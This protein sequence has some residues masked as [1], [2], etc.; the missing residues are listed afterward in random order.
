MKIRKFFE[1][2]TIDD[3]NDFLIDFKDEGFEVDSEYFQGKVLISGKF[4]GELNRIEFLENILNLVSRIESEGYKS[5]NDK[6]HIYTG[7]VDGKPRCS[8]KLR[9][10]EPQITLNKD[11]DSF[12]EFK[13]YLEK[14]LDL[15]FYEWDTEVYIPNLDAEEKLMLDVDKEKGTFVIVLRKGN[16]N[17]IQTNIDLSDVVLNDDEW[18]AL[19][20][21]SIPNSDKERFL[22][23]DLQKRAKSKVFG[24]DK[25]G[26]EAVEKCLQAFKR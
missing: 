6:L 12:E 20:L 24:F 2:N 17:Q 18:A 21:W 22:D 26:I 15:E 13:E 9:F 5:I 4:T 14:G 16:L 1:S 8:F 19:N 10:E 7:D 11:V 25:Q 3:I 23:S